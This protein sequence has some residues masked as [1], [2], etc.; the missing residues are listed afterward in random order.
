M[1]KDRRIV[2]TNEWWEQYGDTLCAM[3][4][5]TD[6][7]LRSLDVHWEVGDV[8]TV[9]MRFYVTMPR[10]EGAADAPHTP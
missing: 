9:D 2:T 10:N 1:T 4:G 6:D 7:G 8:V 3:L 5:I